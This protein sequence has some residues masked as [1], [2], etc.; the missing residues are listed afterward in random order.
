VEAF[1]EEADA[2]D[3]VEAMVAGIIEPAVVVA[4]GVVVAVVVVTAVTSAEVMVAADPPMAEATTTV[5]MVDQV[6]AEDKVGGE[7]TTYAVNA[8]VRSFLP[9]SLAFTFST[10]KTKPSKTRLD[11]LFILNWTV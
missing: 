3:V 4:E 11:Q 7:E 5:T 1:A 9:F 6:V 8:L 2:E 10:A